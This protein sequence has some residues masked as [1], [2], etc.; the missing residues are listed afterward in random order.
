MV[1]WIEE[2]QL[3]VSYGMPSQSFHLFIDGQANESSQF[4]HTLKHAAATQEA[5]HSQ[6]RLNGIRLP[7]RSPRPLY[8][9]AWAIWSLPMNF[10][11]MIR[12][13]VEGSSLVRYTGDVGELWDRDGFV[14]K[15]RDWTET[16]WESDWEEAVDCGI[17]SE[18]WLYVW[19]RYDVEHSS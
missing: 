4:W 5:R 11:Q 1:P 8:Y 18:F 6:L 14:S 15:S 17:L 10:A 2:A 7:P 13:I 12:D 19:E 9:N 16:Q 3:L